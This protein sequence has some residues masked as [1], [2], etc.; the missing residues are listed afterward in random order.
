MTHREWRTAVSAALL[1]FGLAVL[2]G[3]APSAE[4]DVL[5]SGE[6]AELP[7]TATEDQRQNIVPT[8]VR[9]LG[10][11]ADGARYYVAEGAEVE[12]ATAPICLLVDGWENGP[13][14]GCGSM[15]LEIG[16]GTSRARLHVDYAADG[17]EPGEHIGDYLV[18]FAG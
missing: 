5:A 10:E 2:A 4:S 3:C 12:G 7:A 6:A 16:S 15:P 17:S 13:I 1:A 18:V 14:M 8:S 11:D 9:L